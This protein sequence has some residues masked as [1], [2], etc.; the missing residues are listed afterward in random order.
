MTESLH[1]SRVGEVGGNE[2]K[3]VKQRFSLKTQAF[4][5]RESHGHSVVRLQW[6]GVNFLAYCKSVKATPGPRKWP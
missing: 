4:V 5:S 1:V 3:G 2:M 6:R